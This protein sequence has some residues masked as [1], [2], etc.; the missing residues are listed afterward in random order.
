MWDGA[1]YVYEPPTWRGSS[2]PGGSLVSAGGGAE[3]SS[4]EPALC[5]KSLNK[6]SLNSC[7][8]CPVHCWVEGRRPEK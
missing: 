7:L 5:R 6:A 4:A 1:T 2:D 3:L 8:P